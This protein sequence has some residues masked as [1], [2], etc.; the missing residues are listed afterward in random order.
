MKKDQRPDPKP[1]KRPE[2]WQSYLWW[3]EE[4]DRRKR[5]YER[6]RSIERGKSNLSADF[7]RL[8]LR[9]QGQDAIAGALEEGDTETANIIAA[10]MEDNGDKRGRNLIDMLVD[11]KTKA[12]KTVSIETILLEQAKA[13]GPIWDWLTGIKGLGAGGM[14][15]QLLAHI[16]DI[17]KFD[18]VSKLWRFAGYAVIDGKREVPKKG[19]KLH[20]NKLLKSLVYLIVDGFI[21]HHTQPYEQIYRDERERQLRLHPEP[22][23]AN[24][25]EGECKKGTDKEGHTTY[26]CSECGGKA[27]FIPAHLH[28]R[29]MRKAGKI[30]L[31]H[32]WLV[33]RELEGLPVS[34]PYV[35]DVLGHTHIIGPEG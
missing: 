21:K 7:E 23:C 17:G 12:E 33:W 2:L 4:M 25:C 26:R 13:T 6:L 19:E 3:S 35:Q 10:R 18:T 16:D 29:A 34:K 5:I 8:M 11:P 15:A 1:R 30:F 9:K 20:Y 32:L 14:A 24:G 27:N 28:A 22:K 31:Q